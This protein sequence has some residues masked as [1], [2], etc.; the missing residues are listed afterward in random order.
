[1]RIAAIGTGGVRDVSCARYTDAKPPS[2]TLDA[3]SKFAVAARSSESGTATGGGTDVVTNQRL[4]LADLGARWAATD[5]APRDAGNAAEA[6]PLLDAKLT[7]WNRRD[8]KV[9]GTPV[10][11]VRPERFAFDAGV[12]PGERAVASGRAQLEDLLEKH[13]LREGAGQGAGIGPMG[14]RLGPCLKVE[15]RSLPVPKV[16]DGTSGFRNLDGVKKVRME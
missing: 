16:R 12:R 5:P 14:V 4:A 10:T 1:M 13:G 11:F 15:A 7:G 6:T 9:A 3:S 2:P 8:K